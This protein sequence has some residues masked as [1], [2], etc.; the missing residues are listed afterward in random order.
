MSLARARAAAAELQRRAS[1]KSTWGPQLLYEP[2]QRAFGLD[3]AKFKVGLCSRRAGKTTADAWMLLNEGLKHERV[4][5]PYV[6][7]TRTSQAARAMWSELDR[8]NDVHRLGAH[9]DKIRLVMTLPNKA[10]VFIAG[11]D[12][13]RTVQRLRGDKAPGIVV[14]EAQGFGARLQGLVMDAL[15]PS[16]VDMDGWIAVTGTPGLVPA[17]FWWQISTGQLPGWSMHRW[18]CRDNPYMPHASKWLEDFRQKMGWGLDHPTYLREWCAEWVDDPNGLV[19]R[20]PHG[21]R[22]SEVPEASDWRW[23]LGVDVGFSGGTAFAVLSWSS[24]LGITVVRECW[25][26]TG[27]TPSDVAETIHKFRERHDFDRIVLDCDGQGKGYLEEMVQ[28]H[29]L[30]LFPAQKRK[31]R[32]FIDHLNGELSAGKLKA[33]MPECKQLVEDEWDL[34]PWNADR[35]DVDN[36]VVPDHCADAVLYGWRECRP[37]LPRETSGLQETGAHPLLGPRPHLGQETMREYWAKRL[38]DID[39]YNE[40][41]LGLEL[42]EDVAGDFPA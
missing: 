17:G 19:F 6:T 16:L 39:R 30:P 10:Y 14:D 5:C 28:R 11:A 21:G 8:L 29:G 37:W 4:G 41:P 32:H 20:L 12:D 3:P 18:T 36:R 34:L 13:E 26:K 38:A 33:Y 24:E 23:V 25:R 1:V 22:L 2:A 42:V 40:D 31:R 35:S 15:A 27:M 7:L 9:M